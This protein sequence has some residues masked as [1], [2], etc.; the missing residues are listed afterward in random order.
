MTVMS[1]LLFDS[2]RERVESDGLLKWGNAFVSIGITG[3]TSKGFLNANL[4]L[5]AETTRKVRQFFNQG[6][7]E[8]GHVCQGKKLSLKEML[9]TI[10]FKVK[11]KPQSLVIHEA[12]WW[13]SSDWKCLLLLSF[14]HPFFE[15]CNS[16]WHSPSLH[17][18]K[19]TICHNVSR[20][21]IFLLTH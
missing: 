8:K 2:N 9:N 7:V 16:F 6:Q 3:K 5:A 10:T 13:R 12:K 21:L 18:L 14:F 11:L 4:L 15:L 19:A 20:A 1:V 17:L